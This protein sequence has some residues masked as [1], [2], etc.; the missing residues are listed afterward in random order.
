MKSRQIAQTF[1]G[2]FALVLCVPLS[3]MI[4]IFISGLISDITTIWMDYVGAILIP[5]IGICGAYLIAPIEKVIASI[6]MYI[7]GVYIAYYFFA[8]SWYAEGHPLAYQETYT[9]F[10]MAVV[11]GLL[12][13]ALII[14][15]AS[16][17]A[18]SN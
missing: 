15:W 8:P 10:V 12:Y 6:F 16:I 3:L 5:A 13:L 7:I 9:P 14:W 1:M 18:R 17:K 11:F 4:G 2:W